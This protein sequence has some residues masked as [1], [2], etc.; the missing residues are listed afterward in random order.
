MINAHLHIMDAVWEDEYKRM[1]ESEQAKATDKPIND[2]VNITVDKKSNT[3]R[4]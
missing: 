4:K 2:S 1:I 3:K